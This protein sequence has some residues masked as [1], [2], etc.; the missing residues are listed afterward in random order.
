M[1]KPFLPGFETCSRAARTRPGGRSNRSFRDLKPG[2]NSFFSFNTSS[3]NRSFR[4]L[5]QV[6]VERAAKELGTFKPFLPGFET[7]AVAGRRSCPCAGSN[8]SFRDLK[9]QY[10]GAKGRDIPQVQTVPSGI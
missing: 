5:K 1:F 6:L 8:R 7:R 10:L 2:E 4:D 3:S 9:L